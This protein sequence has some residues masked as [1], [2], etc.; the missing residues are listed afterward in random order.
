MFTVLI[1]VYRGSGRT[2]SI[3]ILNDD[4]TEGISRLV[5]SFGYCVVVTGKQEDYTM[6]EAWDEFGD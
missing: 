1:K 5:E 6:E 3:E 2:D 4:D